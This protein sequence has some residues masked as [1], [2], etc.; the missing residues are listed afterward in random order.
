MQQLLNPNF[1]EVASFVV[2][3]FGFPF[4]IFLF[5]YEQRRER[6]SEDEEAYQLLQDAYNDFLKIVLDNPDLQLR[7]ANV[8]LDLTDEQRERKLIIFEMLVALF[9][10]AYIVAYEPD[11]KGVALRRWNSWNDYM[12]E[13]CRRKDFNNL[14]PQLLRGEDPD[15]AAYIRNIADKEMSRIA[16]TAA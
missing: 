3:V 16:E 15:F 9:E 14:L 1:W 13:W 2:T 6:D 12:H 11:L 10:R 4:A 8:S 5:L 7:S